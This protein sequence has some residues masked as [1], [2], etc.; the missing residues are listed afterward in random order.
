[1]MLLWDGS[2]GMNLSPSFLKIISRYTKLCLECEGIQ[3]TNYP[4][5]RKHAQ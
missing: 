1:M 5:P 4:T 2:M 3:F